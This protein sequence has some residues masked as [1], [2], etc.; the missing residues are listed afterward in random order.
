MTRQ[1]SHIFF[2]EALTFIFRDPASVP[3][4]DAAAKHR[5]IR[6]RKPEVVDVY[7]WG[8]RHMTVRQSFDISDVE[9]SQESTALPG[10]L[11]QV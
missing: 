11:R 9:L 2:A 6:T 1:L 7:I 3:G 10:L 8:G 4:W 5:G